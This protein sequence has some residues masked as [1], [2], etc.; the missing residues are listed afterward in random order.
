MSNNSSFLSLSN[1]TMFP[2]IHALA[3]NCGNDIHCFSPYTCC[4]NVK[5][6]CYDRDAQDNFRRSYKLHIWNMWYF[7]FVII[8][9]MMSCFG[10]CGYYRR[11]RMA[12]LHQ[13][14][15][16]API[17]TRRTN[18]IRG[19]S[20]RNSQSYLAY[21][22]P[23]ASDPPEISFLPPPY[24]E[25]SSHPGMYPENK[26]DLPPQYSLIASNY[27]GSPSPPM[28][29]NAQDLAAGTNNMPKPP[30]Y[31]EV[32]APANNPAPSLAEAS[33]AP[34]NQDTY[35]TQ[36]TCEN[37]STNQCSSQPSANDSTPN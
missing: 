24:S 34:T 25:V 21:V 37:S 18:H 13:Q 11:R 12:T 14:R 19:S 17:T 28:A 7:W 4:A 22:G 29:L 35:Q 31:C 3:E 27:A 30:P 6:C 26:A 23:A 15:Q 16:R 9:I 5:S 8:F 10:G 2:F 32:A 20:T 33:A 1:G 36:P